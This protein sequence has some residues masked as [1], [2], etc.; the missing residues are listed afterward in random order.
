MYAN[1]RN[2][3]F[4]LI[5]IAGVN[6]KYIYIGFIIFVIASLIVSNRADKKYFP[7]WATIITA[8]VINILDVIFLNKQGYSVLMSLI[9]MLLIPIVITFICKKRV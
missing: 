9:N 5:P 8:L 3:I 7:L 6:A 1:V 2:F 4:N